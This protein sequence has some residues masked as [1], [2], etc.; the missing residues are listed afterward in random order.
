[1]Y[2]WRAGNVRSNVGIKK[3]LG[4]FEESHPDIENSDFDEEKLDNLE[5]GVVDVDSSNNVSKRFVIFIFFL[6]L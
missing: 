3:R 2:R 5:I 6:W 1:M 4:L